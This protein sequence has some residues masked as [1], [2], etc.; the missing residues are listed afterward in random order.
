MAK[1]HHIIGCDGTWQRDDQEVPTNVKR[2]IDAADEQ[3][4]A[5]GTLQRVMHFDGVGANGS[6]LTRLYNGAT[7]ADLH[8]RVKEAYA[9]ICQ[10]YQDGDDLTLIGF[11]R[12]SY[13][14]RSLNGM[15]YKCGLLDFSKVSNP[16]KA[17]EDAYKFYKSDVKPSTPEA[18]NWRA[19]HAHG[20]RPFVSL[21]CFDTVGALGIPRRFPLAGLFNRGK[22]FHDVTLNRYTR[23]AL[24]AVSIDERRA[25]YMVTPMEISDHAETL[26]MQRY[27]VGDHAGIGGG[28]A[29][30]GLLAE[31]AQHWMMRYM[32]LYMNVGFHPASY[33]DEEGETYMDVSPQ[34]FAYRRNLVNILGGGQDERKVKSFTDLHAQSVAPYWQKREDDYRPTNLHRF[35]DRL[36]SWLPL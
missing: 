26:L 4:S 20:Y 10:N 6:W 22:Q 28:A 5:D 17:I 33:P 21:A 7:G 25:P 29:Q 23:T 35:T 3:K 12:G 34:E 24:H 19:T 30:T 14:A 8:Q 31:K 13:T 2:L 16:E 11:S 27:F 15:I 18:I 36:K 32:H 9:Y 1:T